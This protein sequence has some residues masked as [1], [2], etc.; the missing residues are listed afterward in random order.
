MSSSPRLARSASITA[1]KAPTPGTTRPSA[2]RMSARSEVSTRVG[3]RRLERLDG[4]VHVA[5]SVVEDRDER[6]RAHRAPFVL[7]MPLDE[8]VEGLGLTERT[9]ERLVLGLGDVVRVAA[10]EDA[11]VHRERAVE[12]DRLEG[13]PDERSREVA[14]DQVVLEPCGLPAVDEIRPSAD[15]DDGL[16]ER[17]VE[18]HEGI[19]VP[20]DPGL[21]AECLANRLPQHDGDVFHRVVRVDVGVARGSHREIGE[22]VLREGGQQVVEEGHRRVDVAASGAVEVEVQFDRRFARGAADATRC[23]RRSGS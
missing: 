13:V 7:G 2:S 14:A 22:R 19:A 16:R 11:H 17:L 6:T 4:G 5:R 3:A 15:V 8:R 23:A 9:G 20:G 10:A 12:G 21:V 18:R 1:R